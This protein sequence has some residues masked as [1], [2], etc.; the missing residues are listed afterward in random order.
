MELFETTLQEYYLPM[1]DKIVKRHFPEY[2]AKINKLPK[3]KRKG[4]EPLTDAQVLNYYKLY[5]EEGDLDAR[6]MLIFSQMSLVCYITKEFHY[7]SNGTKLSPED[8]LGFA[9]YIL[10]TLVDEYN[11]Y[12]KKTPEE[13]SKGII[14][15]FPSFIQ[16]WLRFNLHKQLKEYGLDI[17]LPHNRIND[18]TNYKK[19]YSKFVNRYGRP[20]YDEDYIEYFHK[21]N[22]FKATFF[23][24][25]REVVIERQEKDGVWSHHKTI[26]I[27]IINQVVSGNA[28]INEEEGEL[29]DI[30]EGEYNVSMDDNQTLLNDSIKFVLESL[31]DRERESLEL[32]FFK[33]ESVKNIPYLLTPD[34]TSKKE[35]KRLQETSKNEINI[36]INY[37]GVNTP[38]K[39]NIISNFHTEAIDE[40]LLESKLIQT[41]SH[42]FKNISTNK[43]TDIFEFILKKGKVVKIEHVTNKNIQNIPFEINKS[44]KLITFQVSYSYGEIFTSQTFLNKHDK[45]MKKLRKQLKHIK[46][47]RYE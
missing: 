19:I 33:N 20:P 39:Y 34:Y 44:N 6:N 35:I 38:I 31:D 3:N 36:Y 40:T 13:I 23:I 25:G 45:L 46:K 47:R 12:E 1:L 28:T 37:K 24:Y 41:K 26:T 4:I 7:T 29:F 27:Q 30:I 16:T 10:I 2:H 11:P 18:I 22:K 15:K 21:N 42:K 32:Y 9:N 14:N 5:K 43:K 8:L 17:K